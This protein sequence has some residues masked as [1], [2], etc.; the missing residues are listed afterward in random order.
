[1]ETGSIMEQRQLFEALLR[2]KEKGG[3]V[4]FFFGLTQP[5]MRDREISPIPLLF[6]PECA[7]RGGCAILMKAL[8]R[9]DFC[10]TSWPQA[11]CPLNH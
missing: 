6:S 5:I 9:V 8:K 7:L 2:V 4:S 1:M 11:E 10:V 3:G